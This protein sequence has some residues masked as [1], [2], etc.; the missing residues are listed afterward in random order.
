MSTL[1]FVECAESIWQTVWGQPVRDIFPFV[2]V[3]TS[4]RKRGYEKLHANPIS[5]L[6][7]APAAEFSARASGIRTVEN[8]PYDFKQRDSRRSGKKQFYMMDHRIDIAAGPVLHA[9]RKLANSRKNLK[10]GHPIA[11]R[12]GIDGHAR[13][14]LGCAFTSTSGA[15]GSP[16]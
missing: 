7:G 15:G 14:F 10:K 3:V 13:F 12:L 16:R 1:G 4:D 5:E 8:S 9:K 2:V 6:Q 11:G